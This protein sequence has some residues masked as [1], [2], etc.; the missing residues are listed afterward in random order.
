[1]GVDAWGCLDRGG[2][3]SCCSR[4]WFCFLPEFP[5]DIQPISRPLVRIMVALDVLKD[6]IIMYYDVLCTIFDLM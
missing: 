6:L 3:L 1:M 5:G 2:K 4:L